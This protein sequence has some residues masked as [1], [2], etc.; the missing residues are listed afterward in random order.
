MGQL[1]SKTNTDFD[2]TSITTIRRGV[3]TNAIFEGQILKLGLLG[4]SSVMAKQLIAAPFVV[5]VVAFFLLD[6]LH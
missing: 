1:A 5:L 6:Q 2:L 4:L 3:I